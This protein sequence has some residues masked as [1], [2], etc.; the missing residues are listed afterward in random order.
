MRYKGLGQTCRRLDQ[1]NLLPGAAGQ[2][3]DLAAKEEGA[4][5]GQHRRQT[6]EQRGGKK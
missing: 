3:V 4:E 5:A 6:L 2:A 1:L